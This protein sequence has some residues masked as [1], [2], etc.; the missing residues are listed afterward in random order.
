[1]PEFKQTNFLEQ[2]EKK[3]QSDLEETRREEA[4][5]KEELRAKMK[6]N[7]THLTEKSLDDKIVSDLHNLNIDADILIKTLNEYI[8]Q[9]EKDE[10]PVYKN[11]TTP[12]IIIP[13]RLDKLTAYFSTEKIQELA[14]VLNDIFTKNGFVL[15]EDTYYEDKEPA[16][17]K[18]K[19]Q[20]DRGVY[21][22][23]ED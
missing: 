15:K 4:A 22:D 10:E 13:T 11:P 18:E 3:Q 23:D 20:A 21:I 9:R 7:Y 8:G 5:K 14:K 2:A 12:H 6:K 16:P 19:R 1:M 17:K